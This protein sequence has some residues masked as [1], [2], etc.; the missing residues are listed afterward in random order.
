METVASDKAVKVKKPRSAAQIEAFKKG[1]A[2]LEMMR[3]AK[4]VEKE[5]KIKEKTVTID[6]ATDP[7]PPATSQPKKDP[8]DRI[9]PI[10]KVDPAPPVVA[11]APV[12]P[13]RKYEKKPKD[14]ITKSEFDS[15]RNEL[16]GF[17]RQPIAAAPTP[18]PAS[19][20]DPI[21]REVIKER[22]ISGSELLNRIFFR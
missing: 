15:F 10:A 21:I 14:V 8:I 18:P 2:K 7:V 6:V 4:K 12:A 13:K 22:V 5:K 19:N 11:A 17:V 3:A 16:M 9:D 1:I 20:P